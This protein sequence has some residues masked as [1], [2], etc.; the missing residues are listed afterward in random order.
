MPPSAARRAA[1]APPSAARRVLSR[2]REHKGTVEVLK[3][4]TLSHALQSGSSAQPPGA[5][6]PVPRGEQW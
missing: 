1:A 2:G 4:P 5:A 6:A 3:T